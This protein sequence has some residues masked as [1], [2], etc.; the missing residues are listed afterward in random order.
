MVTMGGD[1]TR[2]GTGTGCSLG[3][4]VGPGRAGSSE[5]GAG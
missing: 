4:T 5:A 3:A 2:T 1:R